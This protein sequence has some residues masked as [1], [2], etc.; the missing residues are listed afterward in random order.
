MAKSYPESIYVKHQE[1]NLLPSFHQRISI[2]AD[3]IS[4][5]NSFKEKERSR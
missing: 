4:L 3:M 1:E 5:Q 2:Q